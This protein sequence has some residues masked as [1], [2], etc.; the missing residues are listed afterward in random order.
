MFSL[1]PSLAKTRAI[2]LLILGVA[3]TATLALPAQALQL[4]QGFAGAFAPAKWT[5]AANGG[6]GSV[7]TAGA[8]NSIKLTGNDNGTGGFFTNYSTIA[9]A[10]GPVT[11]NWAY[12][13]NDSGFD[14]FGY[15]LNGGFNFLAN[16]NGETGTTTFQVAV[17]D[18]F[19]FSIDGNDGLFGPGIATISNFS[20]PATVPGPLPLLGLGAA[21]S[22]SRRLRRR[23]RQADDALNTDQTQTGQT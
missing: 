4:Q 18:S 1:A 2:E 5:F 13:T 23:I 16:Q 17:G 10:S 21:F 11:F 22:Y 7:D 6:D 20:A 12:N 14:S 9:T 3:S 8:P 19:G 15:L